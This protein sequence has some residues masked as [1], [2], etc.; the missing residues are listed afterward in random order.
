MQNDFHFLKANFPYGFFSATG[1]KGGV[2]TRKCQPF[3]NFWDAR[4]KDTFICDR[5][6]SA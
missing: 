5:Y 6:V 1:G 3:P 2:S 4:E